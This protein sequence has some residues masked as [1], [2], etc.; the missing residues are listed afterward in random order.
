MHNVRAHTTPTKRLEDAV[1]FSSE[2][3]PLTQSLNESNIF[4]MFVCVV[5]IHIKQK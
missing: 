4:F 3:R 2:N 1:P 5:T